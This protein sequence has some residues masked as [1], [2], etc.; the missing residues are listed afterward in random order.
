M[1]NH[2]NIVDA[3][4]R[5]SLATSFDEAWDALSKGAEQLEVKLGSYA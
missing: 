2:P 3:I 1:T 5:I 4:Q